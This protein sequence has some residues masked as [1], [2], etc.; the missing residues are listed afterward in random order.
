MKPLLI[1]ASILCC[2]FVQAETAVAPFDKLKSLYDLAEAPK[3]LTTA[4]DAVLKINSCAEANSSFPG[5]VTSP[6]HL[7]V[8]DYVSP[9]QG[10]E[11][12]SESSRVIVVIN[13]SIDSPSAIYVASSYRPVLTSQD[14]QLETMIYTSHL[15]CPHNPD[16]TA[17][18]C[19]DSISTENVKLN[20]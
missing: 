16:S 8:L 2:N 13:G 15:K 4:E 20:I 14:L 6:H 18:D 11:F 19:W 12:P 10:P 3:N 5:E 7:A 9:G 17:D 1:L